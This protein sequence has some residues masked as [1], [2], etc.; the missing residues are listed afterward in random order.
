MEHVLLESPKVG[1]TS[2][3][4]WLE[5]PKIDILEVVTFHNREQNELEDY[6]K[7]TKSKISW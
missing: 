3:S 6:T 4:K 2:N 1:H 5:Q 7:N